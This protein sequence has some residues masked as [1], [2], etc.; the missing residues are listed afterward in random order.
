MRRGVIGALAALLTI[1]GAGVVSLSPA[2]PASAAEICVERV[3]V[4]GEVE[5]V[6][7]NDGSGGGGS[8]EGGGG[9]GG[10][11]GPT[12]CS[13]G[14]LTVPCT[15][16]AG[17][18]VGN[19]YVQPADPPPPQDDPIWGGNTDGVIVVCTPP[20][21]INA[22]GNTIP[23]CPE[24]SQ[25]WAPSVPG[26][27]IDPAALARQAVADMNLTMGEI[28][29][30]PPAGGDPSLVGL[31]IWLWVT[32]PAENTTGPI[33]RSAS[34][35]GLTVTATATLDRIEYEL[36]TDRQVLTTT[37]AGPAAPGTPFSSGMGGQNSPTC[38]WTGAQ[39][40]RTGSGTLTG[41]A[42]WEVEWTGAGQS[43][44]ITVPG[45]TTS[46]PFEV[47][48]LQVIRTDDR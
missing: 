16:S 40:N 37:C 3:R 8:D 22:G 32:N 36:Q 34:D 5:V 38:G 48:E 27:A 2:T 43:G 23:D 15:S 35:G 30:T 25:Y 24:I 21:C 19:C 44:A 39:N 46:V 33:T 13:Y 18:W 6:C 1:F 17:T 14:P 42:Y 29:T 12:T 10:G 20:P 11:E 9:S 47:S 26:A 28:G 45:Q 41:T 7:Y 4:D 31:P